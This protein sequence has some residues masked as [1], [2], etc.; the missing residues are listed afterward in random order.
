MNYTLVEFYDLDDLLDGNGC[1]KE[2]IGVELSICD[3]EVRGV[4]VTALDKEGEEVLIDFLP[5]KLDHEGV[6]VPLCI[7]RDEPEVEKEKT[8]V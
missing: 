2:P 4:H 5:C 1:F 8:D 7:L 6:R 3:G